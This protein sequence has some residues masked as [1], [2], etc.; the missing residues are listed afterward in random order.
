MSV[1]E[2]KKYSR[3]EAI[4]MLQ[5]LLFVAREEDGLGWGEPCVGD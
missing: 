3:E 4:H 5:A 1:K 2:I